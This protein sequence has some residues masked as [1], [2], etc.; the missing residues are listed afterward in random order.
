VT[1]DRRHAAFGLGSSLVLAGCAI[2]RP[3]APVMVNLAEAAAEPEGLD[4]AADIAQ[5]MTVP[6]RINGS[7]PYSFVVDT[8]ANRSVIGLEVAGALDLP[9][10]GRAPIH[11]IAG[12]EPAETVSVASLA[13][14]ELNSRRLRLPM[15]PKARLGVDGLLG[16]DV[17]RDR[18]VTLDF[19]QDR[20]RID[21]SGRGVKAV[22]G[23]ANS[24]LR[25]SAPD[26]MVIVPARFRF[27]QLI[28]VDADV[29]GLPVTAFLD[30]GSQNTVANRA[31]QR[32]VAGRL[33]D[34]AA[35]KT[36][37]RMISATGQ[38]ASG[39]LSPLPGLRLGGLRIGRLSAVFADLHIFDVW[40]LK[41]QPALLIGVDVMRHFRSIRI[42][43]GRRQV[44]FH[45]PA[46]TSLPA[47]PP[48]PR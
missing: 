28:I 44:V 5:R 43:F 40:D 30:S 9:R 24:R 17:L 6:V 38:T 3:S 14:G 25:D 7:G 15:L 36:V 46:G 29:G 13:V 23:V 10:A 18:E 48:P 22:R 16:V 1:I 41:E 8:G 47:P 33:P 20:L 39:E 26:D 45:V 11:G 19:E 2:A 34:L 21:A 4:A 31:L 42:D 12:V 27:G 32:A 35:Q 37:V